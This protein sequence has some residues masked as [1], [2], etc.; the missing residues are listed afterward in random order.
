MTKEE[1]G[2]NR[3]RVSVWVF[4]VSSAQLDD[5]LIEAPSNKRLNT[6]S[7]HYRLS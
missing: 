6:V 1:K 5:Y 4:G 2:H 3:D 7:Y